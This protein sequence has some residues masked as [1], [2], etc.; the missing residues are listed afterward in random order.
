LWHIG[1][2]DVTT[3][4]A[5]NCP[6]VDNLAILYR[7]E[8]HTIGVELLDDIGTPD[9]LRRRYLLQHLVNGGVGKVTFARSGQRAVERYAI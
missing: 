2:G 4:D 5:V 9:N 1:A 8:E 6:I 3:T 7:L